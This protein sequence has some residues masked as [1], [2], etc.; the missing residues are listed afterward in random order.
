[1]RQVEAGR[2]TTDGRGSRTSTPSSKR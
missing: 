2:A 1:L